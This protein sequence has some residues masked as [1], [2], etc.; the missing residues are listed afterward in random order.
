MVR[1]AVQLAWLAGLAGLIFQPA[2]HDWSDIS[3]GLAGWGDFPAGWHHR[4]LLRPVP[5]HHRP[6]DPCLDTTDRVPS[7]CLVIGA[8]DRVLR[9]HAMAFTFRSYVKSR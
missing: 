1:L 4:E 2:W 3:V 8:T 5:R 7:V 9:H 6:R